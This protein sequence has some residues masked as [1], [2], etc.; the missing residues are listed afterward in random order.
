MHEI[1]H[2]LCFKESNDSLLVE[3]HENISLLSDCK[4]K[5]FN[6]KLNEFQ[7]F[8][9]WKSLVEQGQKEKSVK[10]FKVQNQTWVYEDDISILERKDG[11]VNK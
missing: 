9:N 6:I 8:N 5:I 11:I 3:K 7:C 1:S 4:F 10:N 2:L